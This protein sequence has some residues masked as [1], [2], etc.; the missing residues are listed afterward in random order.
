MEIETRGIK[1]QRGIKEYKPR[2]RR[3]P[4]TTYT[5]KPYKSIKALTNLRA[6][7]FL[8]IEYKFYDKSLVASAL[9]APT[10]ATGGEH[11][12]SG[13]VM[14]NTV[15]QGDGESNRDGRQ[16]RMCSIQIK[17]TISCGNQA[18]QSAADPATTVVIYLVLDTQTNG[19]QMNSEDCFTNPSAS[20]AL[21]AFPH[22][23]LKF[24]KRFRVLA[25]E[26]IVLQNPAIANDAA[27]TGNIVQQ[28]LVRPFN[29]YKKL[30]TTVNY[31]DTI[32][33]VSAITDN[34]LH[35]IAFCTNTGLA[36]FI[37]YNSRL[38]FVG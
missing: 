3:Y 21:A 30:D 26:L 7:G 34:S 10:G 12:P 1:R 18:T 2:K 22:R 28:G 9:T 23:N 20:A 14:L 33:N 27:A 37:N 38:R 11:D 5:G 8:G 31:S 25:R 36:P 29:I 32:E 13:T 24:A 16:I 4:K 35:V 19:A 15:V 6:A 17:G